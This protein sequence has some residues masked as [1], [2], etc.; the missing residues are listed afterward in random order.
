MNRG[1]TLQLRAS[2]AFNTV[3]LNLRGPQVESA[4]VRLNFQPNSS[5]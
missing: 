4:D 2:C 1:E 3:L 5:L